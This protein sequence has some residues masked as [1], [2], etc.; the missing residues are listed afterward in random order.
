MPTLELIPVADRK[1]F[2]VIGEELAEDADHLFL[3]RGALSLSKQELGEYRIIETSPTILVGETRIWVGGHALDV[4]GASFEIKPGGLPEAVVRIAQDGNFSLFILLGTDRDGEFVLFRDDASY[5]DATPQVIRGEAIAPFYEHLEQ[6]FEQRRRPENKRFPPDLSRLSDDKARQALLTAWFENA[7]AEK[8]A[9]NRSND[10]FYALVDGYLR[11]CLSLYAETGDASYLEAARA[12]YARLE[13]YGWLL[14]SIHYHAA[15]VFALREDVEPM[16]EAL[17][18]AYQYRAP[19]LAGMSEEEAF[20][21]FRDH[22]RL[23]ALR[24][25]YQREEARYRYIT[26][27]VLEAYEAV[28]AADDEAFNRY[29]R[30]K[31]MD[32]YVFYDAPQLAEQEA[33]SEQADYWRALAEK[34]IPFFRN[35]MLLEGLEAL[36]PLD[37]RV[38]ERFQSYRDYRILSPLVYVKLADELFKSAH[39]WTPWSEKFFGQGQQGRMQECMALLEVFRQRLE[40]IDDAGERQRLAAAAEGYEAYS[41]I[42][43]P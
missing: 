19:N 27:E 40:Q 7:F 33:V 39:H 21:P 2:R 38:L 42:C 16:L 4:H 3:R 28:A 17:Y 5:G 6:V 13:A 20:A 29:L 26:L 14:P 30:Q 1:S 9:Y 22:P 41:F 32:G 25:R 15:R 24:E 10:G 11:L 18:R 37:K 36:G 8:F 31:I 43:S 34:S 23:L 12:L 35:Y